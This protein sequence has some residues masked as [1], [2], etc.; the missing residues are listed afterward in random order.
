MGKIIP[1][2]A[3][4]LEWNTGWNGGVYQV[5]HYYR[6]CYSDILTLR[7]ERGVIYTRSNTAEGIF[8]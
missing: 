7:G 6:L 2:I 8:F 1:G 4:F 5:L 3:T